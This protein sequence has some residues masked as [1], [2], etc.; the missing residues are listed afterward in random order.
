M[1]NIKHLALIA[2]LT[3]STIT[4]ALS[5][6]TNFA[7]PSIGIYGSNIKSSGNAIVVDEED[8]LFGETGQSQKTKLAYGLDAAYTF[9]IQKDFFVALGASYQVNDTSFGSFT[10]SV[11]GV[12]SYET[13]KAHSLYI[14]PMFALNNNTAVFLKG[15]LNTINIVETYALDGGETTT[16]IKIKDKF[17]YGFGIQHMINKN[18]FAKLEYEKIDF[19]SKTTDGVKIDVETEAFKIGIGYKF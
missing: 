4:P 8:D 7:G 1:K 18:A 10:D 14:S 16:D 9:E 5:Q 19:G 3:T 12:S 15:S 11:D 17:G 2:L 6:S 13:T